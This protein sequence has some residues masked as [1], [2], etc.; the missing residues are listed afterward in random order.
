M[1][2]SE[3]QSEPEDKGER[4]IACWHCVEVRGM[5]EVVCL[6]YLTICPPIRDA[7]CAEFKVRKALAPASP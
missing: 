5:D 2:I 7:A 3:R 6:A 1:A 4:C